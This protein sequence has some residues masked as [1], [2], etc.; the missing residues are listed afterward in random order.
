MAGNEPSVKRREP[1]PSKQ[2]TKYCETWD[3]AAQYLA[4]VCSDM[5]QV[6]ESRFS[7]PQ[8]D[9]DRSAFEGFV[10]TLVKM[11][12]IIVMIKKKWIRGSDDP[13]RDPAP[14]KFDPT[15]T[16]SP[17]RDL[18]S[19][20][21]EELNVLKTNSLK[22]LRLISKRID[23][24]TDAVGRINTVYTYE[25]NIETIAALRWWMESART[26]LEW[27]SEYLDVHLNAYEP[28]PGDD[29]EAA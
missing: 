23:S 19:V 1:P 9:W 11:E 14:L 3:M 26:Q 20:A 15:V 8:T 27:F 6:V 17:G 28:P 16:L 10:D 4:S 22:W 24:G 2:L 21:G 25:Q 13:A 18:G 5:P 7:H 12:K 29:E